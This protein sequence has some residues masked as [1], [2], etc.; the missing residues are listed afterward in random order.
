MEKQPSAQRTKLTLAIDFRV[1]SVVLLLVIIGM[2]AFWRPWQPAPNANSRTVEVTGETTIKA[3]PDEYV[4]SPSYQFT[5]KEASVANQAANQKSNDL[6]A[7][8]KK[9]GVEDKN[10]KTSITN[11]NDMYYPEKT[12]GDTTYTYT[13]SLTVTVGS[14]D[15]AQQ[16]QDYLTTTDPLGS[17]TP[18]AT[19][20]EAKRK[21]VESQARDEATKDAR[22]KA[23]QN[24]KNLGFKVGAVKTVT[25]GNGFSV[26]PMA[27]STLSAGAAFDTKVS[28]GAV[29]V[30][31]GQNNLTY[32]VTVVYY[33]K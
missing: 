30:Q 2:L 23:E 8:L 31:P 10:L 9:R 19:F 22:A 5:N 15:K 32:S 13:L 17:V 4:F 14:R 12:S 16:V 21:Q 11:Y 24:A 26:M 29:M 20:S 18:S 25:D 3:E 28:T 1:V 33:V 6:V 27:A 7:E